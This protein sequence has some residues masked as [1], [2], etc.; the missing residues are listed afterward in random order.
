MGKVET[1]PRASSLTLTEVTKGPKNRGKWKK[2]EV[3]E[4]RGYERCNELAQGESPA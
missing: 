1:Y 3:E 4:E 2:V